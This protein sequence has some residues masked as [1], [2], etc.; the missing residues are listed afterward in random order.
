[1]GGSTQQAPQA[2]QPANQ[3]GADQSYQAGASQLSSAG[4]GLASTVTPQLA[5]IASNVQSNPYYGQALT[6]A[7]GAANV[8]T[9]QVAPQQ[10]SSAASLQNLSQGASALAPYLSQVPASYTGIT[11]NPELM[12]GLQTLQT[13]YDP[14]STL[15][16]QQYQQQQDQ[17]NAINAMSGVAGTPYGAGVAGQAS[18]NFNTN[19][20]NQQLQRQVTGLGA[21]DSAATTAANNI[22][23]LTG[24]SANNYSTLANTAGS[25]ATTS[26]N[27]GT[28]GLNTMATAAQLPYDLYLQ[29]QQAGLSAL[30][31][32]IQGTNSANALTQQGVADQGA[33]LN[34]GQGATGLNQSAAQ[35]NNQAAQASS[36]GLGSLFGDITGMFHFG[37]PLA[38]SAT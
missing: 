23:A 24:A 38:P 4:Q 33:Y 19:W 34:I 2:Y 29:Q 1:M 32:Q 13:A 26:S 35:I 8:A 14:Q 12:A 30:G 9:S 3:A 21:Y 31:Q 25:A 36:A 11:S 37:N 10:L 18:Q 16:N 28:A 17:Q 6:G 5:S 7:Q 22:A 27:L 20:Q 15:Y